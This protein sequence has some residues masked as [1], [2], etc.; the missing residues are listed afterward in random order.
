MPKIQNIQADQSISNNDKLLGSDSGGGTRNYV[1][2]DVT[3][4]LKNT[5]A[6]G[7]AGQFTYQ[8]KST[9]PFSVGSMRVTF[10]SGL[11]FQNATSIK[12]SK[13]IHNSTQ[14]YEN[15]LTILT[16]KQLLI[17]D[18]EDQDNYGIYDAGTLTQDTSE[19][20]FFNLD[21]ATPTKFNGSFINE[22]FYAIISIG[23]GTAGADKHTALTFTS[24][25]FA[26]TTDSEG[27]VTHLTENINGSTMKYVDFQHDLS[28]RPSITV[29][30][31][32]SPEQVAH[33]PVKYI[34]DNKVRVY[35]T[36]T[37]SG[38]IYAN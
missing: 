14:S 31:S 33:V 36:G 25:S 24:S 34:N 26:S 8:Y 38:K 6:A 10:S 17:V 35:F 16:G 29:A 23:D 37:T 22:R 7:I 13:F 32:G 1:I 2:G 4:F 5:N 3:K 15:I 9:A 18:L 30:E 21:L 19:T 11:T 20:D 12:I 27:N 28:K